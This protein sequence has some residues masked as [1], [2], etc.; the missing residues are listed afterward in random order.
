MIVESYT[1]V[2][3]HQDKIKAYGNTTIPDMFVDEEGNKHPVDVMIE[4]SDKTIVFGCY[5]DGQ[6]YVDVDGEVLP[7]SREHLVSWSYFPEMVT[8]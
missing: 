7:F 6:W 1:V 5:V 4:M 8:S 2:E 3:P